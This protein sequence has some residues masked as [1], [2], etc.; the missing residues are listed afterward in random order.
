MGEGQPQVRAE[1]AAFAI[2]VHLPVVTRA[3]PLARDTVRAALTRCDFADD[4]IA[5]ALL[6]TSELVT[7]AVRHGGDAVFLGLEILEDSIGISVSDDTPAVPAPRVATDDDE[8]GRGL[9]IVTALSTD[10]G[11]ADAPG[12]GKRIWVRIARSQQAS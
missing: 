2:T 3:V 12:G 11:V 1:R 4:V 9:A 8:G 7:N 6:V 5:D 10:W